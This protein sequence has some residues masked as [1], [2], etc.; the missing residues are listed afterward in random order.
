MKHYTYNITNILIAKAYIGVRSCDTDPIKDLGYAYFGSST[1]EDFRLEQKEYPERFLYN[2]IEEFDTREKAMEKEIELHELFGVCKNEDFYNKS[3]STSTGFM[4]DTTG[5]VPAFNIKE[6]I[7]GSWPKEDFD[8]NRDNYIRP[9]DGKVT[10]FN[11]RENRFGLWPKEDFDDNRANYITAKQNKIS[12]YDL[13]LGIKKLVPLDEYK[14]MDY[15]R[16]ITTRSNQYRKILTPSIEILPKGN[17]LRY[18]WCLD[19]LTLGKVAFILSEAKVRDKSRF[20]NA[21]GSG[22]ITK[23]LVKQRLLLGKRNLPKPVIWSENYDDTILA[24]KQR[25]KKE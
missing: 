8:N 18:T 1:D 4:S 9:S 24:I 12:I 23:L 3:K 21:T 17:D 20:P 5:R 16:F 11:I 2:I 13:K 25:H 22:K 19:T 10:A 6:D 7:W 15:S 14:K